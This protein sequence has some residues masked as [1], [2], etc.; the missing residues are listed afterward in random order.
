[1]N[2]KF[3]G[4]QVFGNP[5]NPHIGGRIILLRVFR[6]I[7]IFAWVEDYSRI[8]RIR[9]PKV[10]NGDIKMFYLVI[11]IRTYSQIYIRGLSKI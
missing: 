5:M 3:S 8:L 4:V 10:A 2:R 6:P 7:K 9:F 11:Y 1:M